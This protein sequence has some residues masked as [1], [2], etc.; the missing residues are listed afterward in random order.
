[1]AIYCHFSRSRPIFDSLAWVWRTWFH[2]CCEISIICQGTWM[3]QSGWQ[4]KM[5]SFKLMTIWRPLKWEYNDES[6]SAPD[7]FIKPLR[8]IGYVQQR[9]H[10][11]H[12]HLATFH[13]HHEA[14]IIINPP[15]VDPPQSDCVCGIGWIL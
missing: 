14:V 3:M 1:M 5:G 13:V 11:R 4:G 10:N 2:W 6:C 15:P 8:T 7:I 12:S 9:T